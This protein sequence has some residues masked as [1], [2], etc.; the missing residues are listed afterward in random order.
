MAETQL[1]SN[2]FKQTSVVGELDLTTNPNPS[3][4]NCRFNPSSSQTA[5]IIPGTG[6]KLVDLGSGDQNGVPEVDVLTADTQIAFGVTAIN[7][8]TATVPLGGIVGVA[9]QGAVIR[10]LSS[11]AI[12]RGVPVSLVSAT[13]GSVKALTS[14]NYVAGLTLDKATGSGQL[15]RV[16]LTMNGTKYSGVST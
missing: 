16:L 9:I 7:R 14:G 2:Q 10:M 5:G 8:K 3:I 11:A 13:P 4:L 6:V 12:N 15:I 1:N